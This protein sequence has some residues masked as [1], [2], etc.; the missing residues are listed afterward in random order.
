MI[1]QLA[2]A[3][4]LALL[5]GCAATPTSTTA[6]SAVPVSSLDGVIAGSWRDPANVARDRYRHPAE[7]LAFFG[8]R[9]DQTVIEI[10]PSTGWYTEILA[11]YL[12]NDGQYIGA[13]PA[14]APDSGG[15]KRNAALRQKLAGNALYEKARLIEFDAKAPVFG[16]D[17]SADVV[18]TFRNLHN[19]LAAGTTEYHLR[20]AYDALKPGGV[21]GVVDHR[22]KPGTDIETSKKSGYVSE[23][24]V[25]DLAGEVGFELDARSEVNANPK[26]DTDHPNG[27]WT[28]PPVNRHDAAD[29]AMYKAIGESD[30]MTLRFRKPAR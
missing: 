26:D 15:G 11:P 14:A 21:L 10:T 25:I 9:P 19:W 24:L 1:R 3:S 16:P 5:A 30:R 12:A 18:L 13:I 2:L 23:Q 27:V 28:L 20:A 17:N 6:A 7:T 29:D 22:A 4:C 8:V